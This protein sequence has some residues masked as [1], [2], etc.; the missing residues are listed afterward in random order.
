DIDERSRDLVA[1]EYYAADAMPVP[2]PMAPAGGA[3]M[4]RF[5][6][7]PEMAASTTYDAAKLE[8]A[9]SSETTTQVVFRVAQPVTVA[10]G[11]SLLVPVIDRSVPADL[12]ALYQQ[13]VHG[14]HPL[15]AVRLTNDGE[16]GLPPGV[17]TLYERD[18][19]GSVAYVGDAR[20]GAL[21]GGESRLLSFAV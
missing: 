5:G 12:V 15:A 3:A 6:E 18:A 17:L 8:A 19:T 9:E 11:H 7:E 1:G 20:L 2:A 4:L 21:P 14:S 16:T 10:S 13:E